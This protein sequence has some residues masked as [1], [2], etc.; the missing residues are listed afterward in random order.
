MKLRSKS[1]YSQ[2]TCRKT[3]HKKTRRKRRKPLP[4]EKEARDQTRRGAGKETTRGAREKQPNKGRGKS[5]SKRKVRRPQSAHLSKKIV[6]V[7]VLRIILSDFASEGEGATGASR[8]VLR[9]FRSPRQIRFRHR[10][11]SRHRESLD[12][13]D[14]HHRDDS[15]HRDDSDHREQRDA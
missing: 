13:R 11:G 7:M 10:R 4:Q 3:I 1:T 15:G 14:V 9:G 6:F 8:T 12:H 5:D 2:H